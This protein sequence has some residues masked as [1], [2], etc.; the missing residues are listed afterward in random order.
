MNMLYEWLSI[1]VERIG[2]GEMKLSILQN[3]INNRI[4]QSSSR[5]TCILA[6]IHTF[7][8][9]NIFSFHLVYLF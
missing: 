5:S 1:K 2:D 6:V 8:H 4:S 7:A 3:K 9:T